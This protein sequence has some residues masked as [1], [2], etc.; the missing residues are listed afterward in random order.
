MH[1]L[2]LS[3]KKSLVKVCFSP[4]IQSAGTDSL[5]CLSQSS[6]L[7]AAVF[8]SLI[9]FYQGFQRFLS[10]PL[11]AFI[12]NPKVSRFLKNSTQNIKDCTT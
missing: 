5:H 3:I 8:L 12:G 10:R 11:R 6:V 4:K 7:N 1:E 9:K 2:S